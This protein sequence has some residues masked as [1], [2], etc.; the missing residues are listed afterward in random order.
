M[1]PPA[2]ATPAPAPPAPAVAS[3]AHSKAFAPAP[4]SACAVRNAVAPAAE[5]EETCPVEPALS[6]E[7][8]CVCHPGR[9]R[10]PGTNFLME[11]LI[12][13]LLSLT[14]IGIAS[15]VGLNRTRAFYP[16]V[17]MWIASY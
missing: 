9:S 5:Q 3:P 2:L 14:G 4:R 7:T 17:L 15:T 6:Q 11:Y 1:K 13:L 12:G 16:T 10:K 8:T